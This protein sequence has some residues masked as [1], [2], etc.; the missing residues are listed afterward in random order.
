VRL[1]EQEGGGALAL[2]C[3][4]ADASD[5]QAVVRA[6]VDATGQLDVMFN[7]AGIASPHR[8]LPFDEHSDEDFDRLIAVN[9]RGVFNGCRAAV[10][11][12]KRQ[13]GGGAIVNT[14]SIA[15]LVAVGSVL[16]GATKG[17][18]IQ[19]TRGLAIEVAPL[20]VRV[21]CVCPG[22]MPTNFVQAESGVPRPD[23]AE[24][25]LETLS[26]KLFHPLG[27][28]IEPSDVA[29]A[30]LYLA[31]EKARNVTGIALPV[32]GGYVAR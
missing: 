17:F 30:V 22:G 16:Y 27:R 5:V 24:Q 9:C 1:I 21:N 15:G 14:A 25:S 23:P 11:Q 19:I 7:N 6:A 29:D 20:G 32:D 3:D 8:L 12:F 31:S 10:A 18:I 4:V 13:G 28:T 26:Q 2:C